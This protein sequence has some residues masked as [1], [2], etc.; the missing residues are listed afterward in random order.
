M[1]RP[2]ATPF[3]TTVRPYSFHVIG[4]PLRFEN[5]A[6]KKSRAIM[7]WKKNW[8]LDM[9]KGAGKGP[10][11]NIPRSFPS[12]NL[13]HKLKNVPKKYHSR[14]RPEFLAKVMTSGRRHHARSPTWMNVGC[15]CGSM[16]VPL[17]LL[18]W[19]P[20]RRDSR[21]CGR[22]WASN[23]TCTSG[24]QCCWSNVIFLCFWEVVVD[25]KP[26]GATALTA[27]YSIAIRYKFNAWAGWLLHFKIGIGSKS[28]N[29]ICAETFCSC[30]H[31]HLLP[32][33]A[34]RINDFLQCEIKNTLHLKEIV[35]SM[36]KDCRCDI[37]TP[38]FLTLLLH[39][40]RSNFKSILSLLLTH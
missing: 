9:R 1:S 35:S 34:Q 25:V 31:A 13:F 4:S 40:T 3:G 37:F 21:S 33:I 14:T 20:A 10:W 6:A 22:V 7:C 39:C 30:L 26:R 19:L 16:S 8:V 24:K 32:Q 36:K 28:G 23:G 18:V 29:L 38:L 27:N 17:L 12:S 11:P 5:P 15:W 2:V